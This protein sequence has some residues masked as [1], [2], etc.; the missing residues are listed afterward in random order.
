MRTCTIMLYT[1]GKV[2]RYAVMR[3]PMRGKAFNAHAA[4]IVAVYESTE[5]GPDYAAMTARHA[6]KEAPAVRW[7][8]S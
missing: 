3:G 6:T 8:A 2:S 7:Q 5:A 1:D 4:D